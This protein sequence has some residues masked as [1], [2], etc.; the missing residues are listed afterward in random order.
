MKII[1]LDNFVTEGLKE[2]K[3]FKDNN[4]TSV[5]SENLMALDFAWKEVCNNIHG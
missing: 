3:L 1:L 2:S 5:F 4:K